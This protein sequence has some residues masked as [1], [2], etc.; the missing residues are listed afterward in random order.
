M[1]HYTI[2]MNIIRYY[3]QLNSTVLVL[4]KQK[5]EFVAVQNKYPCCMYLCNFILVYQH[6]VL[7]LVTEFKCCWVQ[8]WIIPND[9]RFD[10]CPTR[11]NKILVYLV[12]KKI[13]ILYIILLGEYILWQYYIHK[14]HSINKGNFFEKR[15]LI[16]FKKCKILHGLKSVYSKFFF[17]STKIF[18]LRLSKWQQIK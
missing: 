1:E 8:S 11:N 18:D 16:F 15:K 17:N 2:K 14:G 5:Y 10:W 3:L 9:I 12:E 4:Y 13:R 6:A 7:L